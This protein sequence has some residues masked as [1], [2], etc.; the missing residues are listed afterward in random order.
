MVTLAWG[1]TQEEIWLELAVRNKM[2]EWGGSFVQDGVGTTEHG[3]AGSRI[4]FRN[5]CREKR[6]GIADER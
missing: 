1:K 6:W 2:A 3:V 4:E 5:H